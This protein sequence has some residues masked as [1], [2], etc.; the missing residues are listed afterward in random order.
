DG[1][2]VIFS[3]ARGR[4]FPGIPS[5][6]EVPV[7]GGLEQPLPTDWGW[8]A[9]YSPDGK[10]LAFNRH[11]LPY[12]RK[13]Y[14]G[15]YAADLWVMDVEPKTFRRVVDDTLADEMRPNNFWPMYGRDGFIYFV[16]DRDVMA[17]AGTGQVMTSV[18][19]IWK[20]RDDGSSG[21]VQVTKHT[22][23][24][25]FW[26]SMSA[27]GRVI[28]YEENF[29]IRKLDLDSGESREI[30]INLVS[31]DKE[32]A[33]ETLTS[34]SECDSYSL[35]PSGRRAVIS[36]HGE[37]FNIAT[38]RGDVR[39]IT[40]TPHAR[41]VNPVWSPDGKWIAFLGDQGGREEIWLCD[42]FGKQLRK[43]SD[44]DS[45]KGTPVWS[46]DSQ[47]LLYPASDRRLYKYSL[48]SGQTSVVTTGE[49]TGF[50]G[51]AVMGPQRSPD[52]KV[53]SYTQTG[54]DLLA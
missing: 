40:S 4:V 29:G 46:P 42:E 11:P 2:R 13:H 12:T 27:D 25:L 32:N 5:L 19:N 1:K 20:V 53:I 10:R 38:D 14:R 35:S 24:N 7:D 22:S 16:S 49:H 34:N 51:M 23:G 15:S 41:E 37:L 28:V 54:P 31:D 39:R 17:K 52:G 9:S 6:Y 33:L 48:A 44:G 21:P 43:V 36:T 50:G 30:K 47:M 45:Q 8:T 18:N 3:S 26:P